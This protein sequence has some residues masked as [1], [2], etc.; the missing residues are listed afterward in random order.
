MKRFIK[1]I[2]DTYLTAK[3]S[4]K[5]D[6]QVP[7]FVYQM[8]KVASTSIY[9]SIRKNYNGVVLHAHSFRKDNKKADIRQFYEYCLR[10]DSYVKIISLIREPIARNISAFFENFTRDTNS[11]FTNHSFS[12]KEL[13]LKNYNHNIPL[14]WF[15][16][17]IKKKFSIDVFNYPF[18]DCGFQIIKENNV[19]L[20]IMKHDIINSVKE[21]I[22]KEFLLIDKF[23]IVNKNVGS[24]KKY[25]KTYKEFKKLTL[26]EWYIEKM[27]SSKYM[28]HFY[29]NETLIR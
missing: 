7:V 16:N 28:K 27:I 15:D 17:N 6:K 10:Q 20:L 26:P 14:I 12:L 1:K 4:R 22:I 18:P 24:K 5:L 29:H 23:T 25:A 11:K 19:E 9:K 3:F 8:G 2:K 13:F 21:S